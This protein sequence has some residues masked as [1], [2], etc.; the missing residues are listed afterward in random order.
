MK[1]CIQYV[2][3]HLLGLIFFLGCISITAQSTFEVSELNF[4]GLKKTKESFLRRI[5]KVKPGQTV[6]SL[7]IETD[8][9]RLKRLD[10]I[11]HATFKVE[12]SGNTHKITYNIKENFS[13]IPGARVGEA[14]D[15]SFSYRVSLFEFN[16]F[17]RN[18]IYG[19][20]FQKE[21]FN[22]YGVFV[23]HPYL[24]TNKLG[25]GVNYIDD[26]SQ[27][28]IYFNSNDPEDETNY[29]YNRRGPEF[30]L[31]YE[32]N[33]HNR[34]ELGSKIF[35]EEYR[36]INGDPE[37]EGIPE[38]TP[39]PNANKAFIRASHEYVDIDIEYQYQ[40]GFR[41]FLDASY[42][43]GGEGALQTEY[44]VN[45]TTQYF[46][47]V[48]AQGN[49]ATQLQLQY[50]NPIDDSFFVPI[51]IDNQINVRGIGNTIDRGTSAVALNAEY[52]HTLYEKKWFVLQGNAFI[53]TAG[54]QRPGED[55]GEI[56][57]SETF[58]VNPGV[59]IRF[60][61]KYIFNA[62][63]RFD[64]GFNVTDNGESGFTFGIGQFF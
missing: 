7:K 59:G 17:G 1:I 12:Q 56:F 15:G 36:L 27:Q 39:E 58:R 63:I 29:T 37:N 43:F 16:G 8:I 28:P 52:R 47:R 21:V 57:S 62:V 33:F 38:N 34:F 45:N 25:L 46:K 5:V 35:R 53:D 10:G 9:A 61:H 40:S 54:V 4:T 23:E 13:I 60:I 30:T 50:S 51:I 55:Y 26:V 48:G 31:F 64:Y 2:F 44:I 32:H 49:F 24:F 41:N 14:N 19:G 6:D 42:F 20:F 22:G 11:A 18:I 3:K